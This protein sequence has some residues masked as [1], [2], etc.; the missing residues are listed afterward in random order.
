MVLEFDRRRKLIVEGLNKLPGF[1][2]IT[3][4]GAF[5][6]FANITAT[7]ISSKNLQDRLLEEAGVATIAG[8]SF[9]A[10]GEGYLRFSYASSAENIAVAL[11][12][13]LNLLE[14]CNET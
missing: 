12:R 14:T 2:C 9:G 8:T 11:A 6:A 3:P 13:T 7:G 1:R 10:L 4:S 5:Y